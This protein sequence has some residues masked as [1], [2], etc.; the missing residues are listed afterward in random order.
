[1]IS[2]DE[3]DVCS[4]KAYDTCLPMSPPTLG[5]GLHILIKQHTQTRVILLQSC[6]KSKK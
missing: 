3:F 6:H 4:F 1:M 2:H 5:G